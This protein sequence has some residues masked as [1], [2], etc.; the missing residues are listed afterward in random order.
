MKC[1]DA[2]NLLSNVQKNRQI[3]M[4]RGEQLLDPTFLYIWNFSIIK[5]GGKF[6]LS[7]SGY[8]RSHVRFRGIFPDIHYKLSKEI[9]ATKVRWI[10]PIRVKWKARWSWL[11]VLEPQSLEPLRW[12]T[13]YKADIGLDFTCKWT[14]PRRSLLSY[15]GQKFIL[16]LLQRHCT[17]LHCFG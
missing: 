17:L 15:K 9:W 11:I 16:C 14:E 6:L 8:P 5:I 3:N 2:C 1:H 13:I 10:I 12:K 7:E 4:A